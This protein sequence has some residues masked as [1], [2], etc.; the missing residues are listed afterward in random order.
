MLRKRPAPRLALI[1]EAQM[2]EAQRALLGPA[3]RRPARQ[4]DDRARAFRRL[5]ARAGTG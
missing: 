5:D 4:V 3:A 2:N 1:D